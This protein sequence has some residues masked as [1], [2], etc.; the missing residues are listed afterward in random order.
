MA[1]F[2]K[3]GRHSWQSTPTCAGGLYVDNVSE[4]DSTDGEALDVDAYLRGIEIK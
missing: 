1:N 4:D 2:G 3:R